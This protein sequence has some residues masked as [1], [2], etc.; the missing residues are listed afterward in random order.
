MGNVNEVSVG[1]AAMSRFIY[2]SIKI[3]A[4][5]FIDRRRPVRIWFLFFTDGELSER[6]RRAGVE[7]FYQSV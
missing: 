2:L 3:H 6:N 4:K 1:F 7:T 5:V